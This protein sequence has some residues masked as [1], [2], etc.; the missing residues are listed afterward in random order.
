M[1]FRYSV[2]WRCSVNRIDRSD[3]V[4]MPYGTLT[5]LCPERRCCHCSI[6]LKSSGPAYQA[7]TFSNSPRKDVLY[8]LGNEYKEAMSR[9]DLGR[10]I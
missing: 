1:S 3:M 2:M 9:G 8:Y 10:E 6:M 7:C 5:I 4:Q